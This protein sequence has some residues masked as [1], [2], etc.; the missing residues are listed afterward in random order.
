MST[1]IN[2]FT[3]YSY[4]LL[5]SPSIFLLTYI[6]VNPKGDLFVLNGYLLINN[7]CGLCG[8][9]FAAF[10]IDKPKIGRKRLQMVSFVTSV[11]IFFITGA[12]FNTA[13]PHLLL[14]LFFM[15]SFVTN[16]MNVTTY[17]CAA[18][19][20]PTELRATCHG[21][22]AFM[23]KAG[24]LLATLTFGHLSSS[25]IFYVCGFVAIIGSLFTLFFSVD[26]TH[27]SLAEHDAQLELFLE[28]RLDDYKGKLN[29][30]KHLSFYET[31]TGRHGD[32][33]QNWAI[34]LVRKDMERALIQAESES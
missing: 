19:T 16:W 22:S 25:Q 34:S 15:S 3:A 4:F 17:V 9:Y 31:L 18:E 30:P 14:F 28:G 8:Y 12:V 7:L 20:Y 26:L 24:A 32:Y 1:A 21:I 33:D 10:V 29:A 11:V 2:T 5:K 13:S 6:S 27:V 23:G